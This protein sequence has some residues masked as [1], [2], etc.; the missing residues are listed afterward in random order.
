MERS[1]KVQNRTT[2]LIG[3]NS[4]R[5]KTPTVTNAIYS[6]SDDLFVVTGTNEVSPQ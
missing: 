5:R 6:I 1:L 4:S 2:G 3:Y